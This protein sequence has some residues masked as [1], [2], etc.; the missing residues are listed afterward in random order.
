MEVRNS[1][2]QQQ[3]I[4]KQYLRTRTKYRRCKYSKLLQGDFLAKQAMTFLGCHTNAQ[5][6]RSG[7]MVT[8][9][10]LLASMYDVNTSSHVVARAHKQQ[11]HVYFL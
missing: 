6:V 4:F 1:L 7:V 5:P 3:V 11:L 9:I 2:Q 10:V 8:V